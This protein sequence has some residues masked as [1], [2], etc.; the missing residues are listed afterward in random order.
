MGV[1]E[2]DKIGDASFSVWR[3][4]VLGHEVF[5]QPVRRV[6]TPHDEVVPLASDDVIS[7]MTV[8][9]EVLRAQRAKTA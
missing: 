4:L 3:Q 8:V 1:R 5:R 9:A 7:A 6:L 2:T